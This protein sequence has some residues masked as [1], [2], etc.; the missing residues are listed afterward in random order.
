MNFMSFQYFS[1]DPDTG[2]PQ[3]TARFGVEDPT[4]SPSAP[5]TTGLFF[6][7]GP[8]LTV[9]QV[10]RNIQHGRVNRPM[11]SVSEN[12]EY[13]LK[14]K[15]KF[16][17]FGA[18]A[19]F[20]IKRPVEQSFPLL[21]LKKPETSGLLRRPPIHQK[22]E[23]ESIYGSFCQENPKG[24]GFRVSSKRR[25]GSGSGSS[26]IVL[27][28]KERNDSAQS[29]DPT[30]ISI[31]NDKGSPTNRAK[32]NAS[33]EGRARSSAEKR[34]FRIQSRNAHSSR[35]LK[36]YSWLLPNSNRE[37]PE[38]K[39]KEKNRLLVK[40]IIGKTLT[41]RTS[42]PKKQENHQTPREL[43]PNLPSKSLEMAKAIN[44]TVNKE[45]FAV[46]DQK[47]KNMGENSKKTKAVSLPKTKRNGSPIQR[48]QRREI[49]L[50]KD[51]E[52]SEA[53]S[54]L[55]QRNNSQV[56]RAA[57]GLAKAES[58]RNPN[59]FFRQGIRLQNEYFQTKNNSKQENDA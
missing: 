36:K 45:R 44:Q 28:S 39:E 55:S 48:I 58:Y 50:V 10:S 27:K 20:P 35:S 22:K 3:K 56:R 49:K 18:V 43:K 29:Q 51:K 52:D 12:S 17:K 7:S 59:E 5:D 23:T 11:I 9:E 16:R 34:E 15:Q 40:E 32:S 41:K 24:F 6:D 47:E 8:Q 19:E 14:L 26:L 21:F 46:Q 33:Q 57:E 25:S 42:S 54:S 31:Q 2:S 13:C 53:F 37:E 38:Q 30:A 4:N 1:I